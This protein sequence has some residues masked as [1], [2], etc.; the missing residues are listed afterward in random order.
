MSLVENLNLRNKDH[1]FV[2][3]ENWILTSRGFDTTIWPTY[4]HQSEGVANDHLKS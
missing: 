3:A 2:P 4:P 1:F